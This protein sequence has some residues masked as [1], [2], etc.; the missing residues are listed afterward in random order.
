LSG[1]IAYIFGAGGHAYVVRS[2]IPH[3]QARF[4]VGEDQDAVFAGA[5]DPDADYFIGIGDNDAR[6]AYFDRL[7]AFGVTVASCIAPT[8]WVAPDATLGEGL[9]LGPGAAICARTR[10]GNNVI[11]NTHSSVD[12]DCVIG[13]DTQLTPGVTLGSHLRIGRGCF[14]GMKSC[15]LPR[16]EIGDRVTAMAGA[17]VVRSAPAGV[18]LGGAPARVMRG[19][20]TAAEGA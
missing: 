13:D 17:L 3:A 15:V 9:F 5:P 16:I 10:L 19:E 18:M 2:L 8:A 7:K 1:R 12:H 4:L 20:A 11:V 14:F 6:R